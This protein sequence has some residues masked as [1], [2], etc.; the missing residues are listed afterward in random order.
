MSD[1]GLEEGGGPAE[2]Q[3]PT[4]GRAEAA[5]ATGA[6]A[7]TGAATGGGAWCVTWVGGGASA[8]AGAAAG[9]R[10]SGASKLEYHCTNSGSQPGCHGKRQRAH[11]TRDMW[12]RIWATQAAW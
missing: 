4:G 8:G 12:A 6:E 5:L 3:L 11:E 10:E 2:C 7:R 1:N 9:T